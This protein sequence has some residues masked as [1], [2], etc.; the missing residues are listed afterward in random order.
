MLLKSWLALAA[1]QEPAGTAAPEHFDA[2]KTII[3][4]VSNTS[5]DEPLISLP[6]VLVRYTEAE[7]DDHRDSNDGKR[8]PPLFL[9][10]WEPPPHSHRKTPSTVLVYVA[11]FSPGMNGMLIVMAWLQLTFTYCPIVVL[12]QTRSALTVPAAMPSR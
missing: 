10:S 3:E 8:R 12:L 4:H 9:N 1:I 11:G 6:H 7:Q 5:H 2:G